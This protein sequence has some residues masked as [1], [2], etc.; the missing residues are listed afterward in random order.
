[1]SFCAPETLGI[2]SS[3]DSFYYFLTARNIVLGKGVTFDGINPT[4]G[5]HPLWML[6]LIPVYTL[7]GG[8]YDLSLRLVY[9]LL[10]LLFSGS[11][12]L[13]FKLLHASAGPTPALLTL[14][15]FVNPVVFN[16]FFNGLESALLIFLLLLLLNIARRTDLV[17]P[18][19]GIRNQALAGLLLGLL[20]LSRLDCAFHLIGL[21]LV[22]FV[23]Y[24]LPL[25]NPKELPSLLR[26]YGLLLL[27]FALAVAPY[28]AWNLTA[29][30]HLTPISGALKS[31]FPHPELRIRSLI[32]VTRAPYT[33]FILFSIALAV[34]QSWN[35]NSPLRRLVATRGA[36]QPWAVLFV[37]LWLGCLLHYGYTL[38]F[39]TWGTHQWHFASYIPVALLC[40][41][42]LMARATTDRRWIA[43]ALAL[44][45][46]VVN[47]AMLRLSVVEKAVQHGNW[48]DAAI[49]ARQH[50]PPDSVFGM[51]DAGYFAYFS[52][53]STVNL[54]GLING[55]E[56]QAALANGTLDPYFARCGINYVSD[57]EVPA[58]TER[59]H[60][61]RLTRLFHAEQKMGKMGYDLVFPLD[62]TV[63]RSPPYAPYEFYVHQRSNQRI[64]FCIWPYKCGRLM[65][66]SVLPRAATGQ[67][68]REASPLLQ[69]IP[70]PAPQ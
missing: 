10:L 37:G 39:T 68:A 53:R 41:G 18:R 52:R 14:L 45:M 63:Y 50:T 40:I 29:N 43:P 30:G 35:P 66:S 58:S 22:A 48:S 20:F 9:V 7:T 21:G 56:Y 17:S 23:V 32:A 11:I 49:W 51:T 69:K 5:F 6:A 1:V 15:L 19:M 31:S 12:A 47:C 55:Y 67:T 64:L 61:I 28:F 57:Y 59:Y 70:R 60:G 8:D 62:Q 16:L 34:F 3:D 46:V 13:T 2:F 4:N 25:C 27:V 38:F 26:S 54:D 65:S 42:W 36:G 44:V 33:L 24:R